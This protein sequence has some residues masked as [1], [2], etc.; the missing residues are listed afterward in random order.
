MDE[1]AGNPGS[2]RDREPAQRGRSIIALVAGIGLR[3]VRLGSVPPALSQDEAC[4]GYDAYSVP[5]TGRAITVI[6]C[7][8]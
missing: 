2:W 8:S 5:A 6:F 7:R 4:D 1:A 3:V